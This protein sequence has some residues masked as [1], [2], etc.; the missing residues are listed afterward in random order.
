MGW[1]DKKKIAKLF[2]KI[3]SLERQVMKKNKINK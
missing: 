1:V 2:L 3:F